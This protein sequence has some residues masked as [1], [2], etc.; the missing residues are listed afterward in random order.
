MSVAASKRERVQRSSADGTA[1]MH[2]AGAAS[3]ADEGHGRH[4]NHMDKRARID[5]S[6]AVGVKT[7]R[8]HPD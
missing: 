5:R 7:T 8:S 6:E 2:L 4:H 3:K 1:R